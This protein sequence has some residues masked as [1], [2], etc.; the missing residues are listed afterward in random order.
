MA[1]LR[2]PYFP[3]SSQISAQN[4]LFS[5]SS[6][7]SYTTATLSPLPLP[8]K[9]L[10]PTLFLSPVSSSSSSIKSQSSI[11]TPQLEKSN[12]IE[13]EE[14]DEA[15]RTR[16]LAQNVP[17]TCTAD[18][19]RALFENYGTVLDVEFSMY[20]KSR[21]RGLVFV[22]MGSH[23]E[24]VAALANLESYEFEGRALKLSWAKPKKKK[25][26]SPM[27]PKPLP[28]HNLFVANLPFQARANDLKEFFNSENANVVSAEVIFRDNPRESA[29]YGF[30]SF[31]TKKEAEAALSALQG[32]VFMGRTIRVEHSKRFLRQETK[33][34]IESKNT[35]SESNPN[36][37]QSDKPAEV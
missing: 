6:S 37:V 24:A 25:P 34:Q 29:G 10:K 3:P 14:E 13:E 30:V 35:S 8:I 27:T 15:S 2:L 4:L 7:L 16:L 31:K 5:S 21:N 20:N 9:T 26:S 33:V 12:E 19:I 36:G 22:S 18:E 11:T 32:K 17:W 28:V 23:E 1:L